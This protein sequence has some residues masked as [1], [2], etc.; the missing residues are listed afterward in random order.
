MEPAAVGLALFAFIYVWMLDGKVSK[1]GR[2]NTRFA[3]RLQEA[4]EKIE[5]LGRRAN[6]GVGPP[7]LKDL[8]DAR[9]TSMPPGQVLTQSRPVEPTAPLAEANGSSPKDGPR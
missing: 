2:E 1:L 4:E 9:L 8:L 7:R 5:W 3:A 6:H